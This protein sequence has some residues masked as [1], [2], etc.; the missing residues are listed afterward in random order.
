MIEE[1]IIW[2]GRLQ[3]LITLLTAV[4]GVAAYNA[5]CLL[6]TFGVLGSD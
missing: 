4:A 5:V 3:L 6:N 1:G 2:D